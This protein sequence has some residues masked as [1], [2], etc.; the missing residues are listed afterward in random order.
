VDC[1]PRRLAEVARRLGCP[2]PGIERADQQA[3]DR[4]DQPVD[5]VLISGVTLDSRTVRP[6]DLY[7]ALPGARVHGARFVAQAARAGAVAVLTDPAGAGLI[8]DADPHSPGI[9]LPALVVPGPRAVLGALAAWIYG[10][11][12]ERLTTLGVTGT[13]GKTT[14]TFL[15]DGALRGLGRRTG[16]VGTVEIKVGDERVA[17][18]RTTPEAPD[19]HALL[20][21]M[22][23]HGVDTCS[24][25]VSSHALDQHRVDGLVVDVAGFTN[26]SQDHLDYH[27]TL[28]AYFEAKAQLFTPEHAA[29]GV[30]CVDDVWGRRLLR[31]ATVP[32]TSVRTRAPDPA[33]PEP[34]GPADWQVTGRWP[35]DG[36]RSTVEV[37]GPA[38]VTGGGPLRLTC[39]LPGEFNVENVVLALVM[40]VRTGVDPATAARAVETA[41]PVPG[42]M[43]PVTGPGAVGEPLTV[44]DYAHTP[45]AVAAV[46][47]AL[48]GPRGATGPTGQRRPLVIVLGAG[49]DRDADKRPRM[50]EA[51]A[52][53]ADVVL[54][55]DDNPRSEDPAAIR[56]TVLAGAWAASR[57]SGAEV[58]EVPGR[59][60]AIVEGVARA[61]GSG[62]LLIAGK[63]HEL[64][65]EAAGVV[66]PFDDRVVAREAL[67]AAAADRVR[68]GPAVAQ[69]A[70][71][72]LTVPAVDRRGSLP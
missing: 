35:A 13:N 52:L 66:H 46:L 30:V 61:W 57:R 45:D 48:S 31:R 24:F 37:T 42:R 18:A 2:L 9:R 1:S 64:G 19:L 70:D 16:L 56:A 44:V 59:R 8:E 58:I 36:G 27:H 49:G 26:L 10:C 72:V 53:G 21:V 4:A 33:E 40:L 39:P 22:L 3:D 55:T 71:P 38:E 25:E 68:G 5:E 69:V 6:G 65:Q 41:G 43:E 7:A 54:V 62:V 60:A 28:Q 63:G 23:E 12:G 51:A 14:T 17:S 67:V 15:L 34:V 11:P 47:A 20:A 29:V 50:G 32:V